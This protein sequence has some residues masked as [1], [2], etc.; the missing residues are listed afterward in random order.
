M[1]KGYRVSKDGFVI[2][3]WIEEEDARKLPDDFMDFSAPLPDMEECRY[4]VIGS[5]S[6]VIQKIFPYQEELDTIYQLKKQLASTDYQVTKCMEAQLLGND[7]PY[8]I[9]I[10]HAQRQQIRDRINELETLIDK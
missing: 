6:S 4:K 3:G 7:L 5:N 8:E 9:N 2:P 1:M 10:L